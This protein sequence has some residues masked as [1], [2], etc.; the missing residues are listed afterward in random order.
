MAVHS[1]CCQQR[2]RRCRKFR[3]PINRDSYQS[4]YIQFDNATPKT[5]H[6]KT[7]ASINSRCRYREETKGCITY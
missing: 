2:H 5:K 6:F 4:I 7:A 1:N 3:H